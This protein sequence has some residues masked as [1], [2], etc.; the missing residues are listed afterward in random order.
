MRVYLLALLASVV[1]ASY[2][3]NMDCSRCSRVPTVTC[4]K[5]NGGPFKEVEFPIG[6][7]CAETG[8]PFPL[9]LEFN[10]GGGCDGGCGLTVKAAG[11]QQSVCTND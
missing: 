5:L 8:T 7:S 4:I 1:L 3:V 9:D 2:D 6:N 10:C 11:M